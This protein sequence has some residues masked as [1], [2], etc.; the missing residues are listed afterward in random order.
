M[1]ENSST[2]TPNNWDD[3]KVGDHAIAER[4]ATIVSGKVTEVG[5]RYI[6]IEHLIGSLSMLQSWRLTHIITQEEIDG[7]T[8]PAEQTHT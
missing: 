6:V 5:P 8:E 4:G 2:T 7:V 1:P 3:V